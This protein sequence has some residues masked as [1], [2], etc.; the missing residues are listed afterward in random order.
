MAPIEQAEPGHSTLD[1][2]IRLAKKV[3]LLTGLVT[4]LGLVALYFFGIAIH[5]T[6]S[7]AFGVPPFEFSLQHCL[8]YGGAYAGVVLTL[9]PLLAVYGLVDYFREAGPA[10]HI[11]LGLP[12]VLL[13]L[14]ETLRRRSGLRFRILRQT[15]LL[16]LLFYT[17]LYFVIVYVTMLSTLAPRSLLLDP[18]VNVALSHREELKAGAEP[19][20]FGIRHWD[21]FTLNMVIRDE[22]WKVAKIGETFLMG[23][24]AVVY[25]ILTLRC[26]D[27]SIRGMHAAGER[28]WVVT[29]VSRWIFYALFAA[30]LLSFLFV[31]PGRTVVM[32]HTMPKVD[33]SIQG[34]TPLTSRYFLIQVAEYERSYVFYVPPEQTLVKVPREQ[35]E[36]VILKQDV[37]PFADRSLFRKGSWVGVRGQWK[38]APGIRVT[39]GGGAIGFEVAAV[40][41]DSAAAG[42]GIVP[43]D[44][45]VELDGVRLD[46]RQE[47]SA[48]AALGFQGKP[49]NLLVSRGGKPV[50]LR[51]QLEQ[52]R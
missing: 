31:A 12:L 6:F 27:R 24:L 49:A 3:S 32:T 40:D 18:A 14:V 48:V 26:A 25:G 29:A 34:L 35:V 46:G 9:L 52:V 36:Y 21:G 45:L 8:E 41:A 50:K 5:A 13:W 20:K 10:Q 39:E 19:A 23:L 1:A 47:L 44:V 2:L 38:A 22:Q 30:V 16:V 43:G 33:V 37:S 7:S 15:G 17:V 51:I 42:A 28:I 4:G 11:F